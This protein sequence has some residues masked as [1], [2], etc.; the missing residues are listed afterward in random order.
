MEKALRFHEW[1]VRIGNIHL[2]DNE[3]MT[4]AYIKVEN[5]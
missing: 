4:N 5:N 2:A 3:Q 1:M